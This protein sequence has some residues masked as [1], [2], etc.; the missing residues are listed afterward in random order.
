MITT[1]IIREINVNGG[2]YTN[3]MYKVEI[4][5]FNNPSN[6]NGEGCILECNASLP[7]GIYSS[8]DVGDMVYIGFVNNAF[9]NPVILGKIYKGLTDESRSYAHF[10]SIKVDG[11]VDLPNGITINGVSLDDTLTR[12][13][14]ETP[15]PDNGGEK[16]SSEIIVKVESDG[17][18]PSPS[19][20]NMITISD[21]KIVTVNPSNYGLNDDYGV[22]E[23]NSEGVI[24]VMSIYFK[25]P[26]KEYIDSLIDEGRLKVV[27]QRR[28][29]GGWKTSN[30]MGANDGINIDEPDTW[31]SIQDVSPG[32]IRYISADK[33]IY[34][35]LPYLT[36]NLINF[37]G[38][39][40]SFIQAN[41]NRMLK[42]ATPNHRFTGRVNKNSIPG[43]DAKV[44]MRFFITIDGKIV[45][46][47]S[48]TLIIRMMRTRSMTTNQDIS[49]SVM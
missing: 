26:S 23:L 48:G 11:S 46:N 45:S 20:S 5:I 31:S 43:H 12:L 36:H 38:E 49:F 17:S 6:T 33:V 41:S 8:Y 39:D 22:A 32:D 30:H 18:T 47:L 4:S 21:S 25:G 27:L 13:G 7:G 1:G 37:E 29:G 34:I 44:I 28:S 24:P 16:S 42:L 9:E 3:N 40:S 10:D 35:N 2:S 15:I 14:I 19:S